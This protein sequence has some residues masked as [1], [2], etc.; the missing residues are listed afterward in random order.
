MLQLVTLGSVAVLFDLDIVLGAFAAGIVLRRLLPEGDGPLELRLDGLAFGFFVPLFFVTSGMAIDPAAVAS[1]PGVLAGFIVLMLLI[2]GG[3]VL[4]SEWWGSRRRS[5]T[6]GIRERL[7]T[8]LFAATGL[9]IIVAVSSAA[10]AAGQMDPRNASLMVAGGAVTVLV[11]PFT[12][13]LLLICGHHPT[14]DASPARSP[15]P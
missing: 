2:R 1:E 9:A 12:A 11:C 10:V 14:V 13:T 5:T 4:A 8:S 7:A 6:L 3:G 15:G